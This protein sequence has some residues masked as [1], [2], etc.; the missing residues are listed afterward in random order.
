[1]VLP[2]LA[3]LLMRGVFCLGDL[4]AGRPI[5]VWQGPGDLWVWVWLTLTALF[6]WAAARGRKLPRM[7]AAWFV[8]SFVPI[9]FLEHR[10]GAYH[11]LALTAMTLYVGAVLAREVHEVVLPTLRTLTR[12]T[13]P[14]ADWG[15]LAV[16]A[17]L[18]V[19][20]LGGFGWMLAANVLR[21]MPTVVERADQ[22]RA[23]RQAVEAAVATARERFASRTAWT[24]PED[25]ARLAGVM[26]RQRYG[27]AWRQARPDDGPLAW[28]RPADLPLPLYEKA[29][30]CAETRGANR[31]PNGDFEG[32]AQGATLGG[33]GYRGG[34]A[35]LLRLAAD[36]AEDA[37]RVELSLP[38]PRPGPCAFGAVVRSD[39]GVDS[40]SVRLHVETAA[41]TRAV[42]GFRYALQEGWDAVA[43]CA[44]APPGARSLRFEAVLKRRPGAAAAALVDD[45]FVIP[46]GVGAGR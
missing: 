44:Q 40:V 6:V 45:V 9:L 17:A 28:F 18:V 4:L 32:P 38:P 12:R 11:L 27:F 24:M 22:G 3:R 43:G 7:L 10:S 33:P 23:D 39:A 26:L 30:P 29:V 42:A 31:I 16:H 19:A 25:R 46:A 15:G 36:E 35:L 34:R 37:Q 13:P 5:R 2:T 41:G 1:M 8:V 21:A 14:P 20:A